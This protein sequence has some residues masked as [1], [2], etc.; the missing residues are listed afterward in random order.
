MSAA[1]TALKVLGIVVVKVA[2]YLLGV[3]L[4][5]GLRA[6]AQPLPK[7]KGSVKEAEEQRTQARKDVSFEVKGTEVRGWLYLPEDLS[8]PAP[9]I[10]M[11][12][13]LGGVKA[14]GL[15]RYALRFQEAGFAALVFD[16]RYQGESAGEPRGLIWIPYQL[17]DWA[18]A[19][20]FARSLPEIDSKRIGLWGTSL[21]GG[22]VL[23]TAARDDAIACVSAQAPA[24][25]MTGA[26]MHTMK[27]EGIFGHMKKHGVATQLLTIMHAQRD[28]VRSWLGLS[29]HKIPLVGKPGTIAVIPD[30]EAW[31]TMSALAPEGFENEACARIV[32]RADKYRAIRQASGLRCPVLLQICEQDPTTP[33]AVVED[34]VNRLGRRAE[35][36]RYPIG[37]FDIYTGAGFEKAVSDQ[38]GFFKRH[39]M[40]GAGRSSADVATLEPE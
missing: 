13:G 38:L 39:L 2:V 14:M 5:P 30:A 23:V 10:V 31:D 1:K 12:H 7:Q 20:E 27:T 4:V 16:Y 17:E 3:A 25:D 36:R 6:P 8:V 33:A 28:L 29:P 9:C 24:L 19:V 18:A 22:H 35:V 21:S 37:H 34:A 15:E 32:I 11:A 26:A 40:G